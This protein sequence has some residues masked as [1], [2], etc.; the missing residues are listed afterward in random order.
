M[1]E[2]GGAQHYVTV[3]PECS[4]VVGQPAVGVAGPSVF[5][6]TRCDAMRYGASSVVVL[7]QQTCVDV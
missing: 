5:E 2:Q 4:L 6:H 3:G 7:L 1:G